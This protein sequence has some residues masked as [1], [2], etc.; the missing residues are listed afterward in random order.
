[1]SAPRYRYDFDLPGVEYM[2]KMPGFF[3]TLC[4]LLYQETLESLFFAL[5]KE[6]LGLM[7]GQRSGTYIMHLLIDKLFLC[8]QVNVSGC[9][10]SLDPTFS[11]LG[12]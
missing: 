1:M 3:F 11:Y 7:Q 5:E 6:L 12:N 8:Q 10:T 9:A 2:L 4:T